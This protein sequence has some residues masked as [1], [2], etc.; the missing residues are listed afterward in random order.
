MNTPTMG[1]SSPRKA[2]I[3]YVNQRFLDMFGY[4]GPE[5]I[6]GKTIAEARHVHPEDRGWLA[7]MNRRRPKGEPTPSRYEHRAVGKNGN[8]LT[9]RLLLPGS[10]IRENRLPSAT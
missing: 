5:E 2:G 8:L 7:E 10:S 3:V 4:D 1:L 6:I 9:W